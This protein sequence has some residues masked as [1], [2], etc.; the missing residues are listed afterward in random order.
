MR[1]LL[2]LFVLILATLTCTACSRGGVRGSAHTETPQ[3]QTAVPAHP[4]SVVWV[5]DFVMDLSNFKADQGM[6]NSRPMISNV[7]DIGRGGNVPERARALV[8]QMSE[9]LVDDLRKAGF[10]AQR[11]PVNTQPPHGGWLIEGE[12]SL[13][14]EGNRTQ[15]AVLG[16]GQGSS[17]VDVDVAVSDLQKP[18]APFAV[19]STVSDPAHKPGGIVT[20]NPYAMAARFVLEKKSTGH[21]VDHI[22]EQIVNELSE[23]QKKTTAGAH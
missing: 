11:L 20:M 15:R 21:D 12:F 13:V 10:S 8:D 17:A 2:I 4:A 22:S 14:D 18:N 3:P 16:M 1:K 5:K 7:L 6:L 9:S 19:F 23:I